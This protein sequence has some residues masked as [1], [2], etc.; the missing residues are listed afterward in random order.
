VFSATGG[1][2]GGDGGDG[3]RGGDGGGGDGYLHT[4]QP[5]EVTL[6]SEDHTIVAGPKMKLEGAL[7][8]PKPE[9]QLYVP[10]GWRGMQR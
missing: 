3:G 7:M 1:G 5:V 9:K 6:E 8:K 2:E 10:D 4:R